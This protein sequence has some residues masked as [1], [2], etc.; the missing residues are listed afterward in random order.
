MTY[1]CIVVAIFVYMICAIYV[2]SDT[3]SGDSYCIEI[4]Q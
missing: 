3:V 4:L 1:I 2:Y